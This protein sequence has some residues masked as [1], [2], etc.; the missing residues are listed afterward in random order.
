MQYPVNVQDGSCREAAV[1]ILPATLEGLRVKSLDVER[2]QFRE[3]VVPK[4]RYQIGVDD[5]GVALVRLSRRVGLGVVGKP[6]FQIELDGQFR[7]FDVLARLE[8]SQQSN[9]GAF[10]VV[11][12]PLHGV[13][14]LLPLAVGTTT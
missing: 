14:T 13:P 12:R 6:T 8:T 2:L 7:R 1:A 10:G 5:F 9:E 11:A 4:C 3:F